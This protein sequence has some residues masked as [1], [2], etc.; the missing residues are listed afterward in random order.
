MPILGMLSFIVVVAA[1]NDALPVG[2]LV[3]LLGSV[4]LEL[5]CLPRRQTWLYQVRVAPIVASRSQILS[6]Q[7]AVGELAYNS[8]ITGTIEYLPVTL[9][10]IAAKECVSAM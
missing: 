1:P 9:S 7:M 10:F 5:P 4:S 8:T 6:N 3:R 2:L